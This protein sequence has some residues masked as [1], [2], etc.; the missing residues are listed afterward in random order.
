MPAFVGRREFESLMLTGDA[1][2][3]S[4]EGELR[5]AQLL[6]SKTQWSKD[7][8]G[9]AVDHFVLWPTRL[10]SCPFW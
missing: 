7:T 9:Q 8:R 6:I 1:H 2:A 4:L 3:T 10:P 5:I